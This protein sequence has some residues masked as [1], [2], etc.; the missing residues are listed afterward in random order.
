MP[1]L[2]GGNFR[3]LEGIKDVI[4]NFSLERTKDRIAIRIS[5]DKGNRLGNI[6]IEAIGPIPR[7]IRKRVR[8]PKELARIINGIIK[9]IKVD[10]TLLLPYR[11]SILSVSISV[12]LLQEGAKSWTR[13]IKHRWC[14]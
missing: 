5:H 8:I 6:R 4:A 9:K 2:L 12:Q 3:L 1:F 13:V 7:R 11:I 14:I 10:D